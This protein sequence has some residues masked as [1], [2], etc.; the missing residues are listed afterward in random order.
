[1]YYCVYYINNLL[2]RISQPSLTF[3]KRTRNHTFMA[4]NRASDMSAADWLSQRHVTN[5]CNFSCVVI[6]FFS[7]VGIPIRHSSLYN[8]WFSIDFHLQWVI[9]NSVNDHL[10]VSLIAQL[11]EHSTSITGDRV[12]ILVKPQN[13]SGHLNAIA[14]IALRTVMVSSTL[15]FI[16]IDCHMQTFCHTSLSLNLTLLTLLKGW[17]Q[18][19]KH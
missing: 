19:R 4:L 1:M 2:T 13:F 10:Q 5:Y 9:T 15:W 12:Q 6:W 18:L 3:K 17:Y 7:E 8:K 14:I 11:V 16:V